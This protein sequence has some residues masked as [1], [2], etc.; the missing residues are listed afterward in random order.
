MS[1]LTP[2]LGVA[3]PSNGAMVNYIDNT[4]TGRTDITRAF[5]VDTDIPVFGDFAGTTL[6][7]IGVY[8]PSTGTWFLDLTNGGTATIALQFGGPQWKPITGDVDGNGTTDLGLYN[9]SDGTWLFCTNLSGQASRSFV[10]GGSAGDVPVMADFNHD[11]TDDPVIY[12]SGQ[13]LVDTNADHVP[14]QTYHFGSFAPGAT[15]LAFDLYGN[16]DPGLAV[17]APQPNGQL[18]WYINPNRDGVTVGQY[19]YGANGSIPFSGNFSTANSLFVNPSTGRDAS[20]AGAYGSPYRTIAAAVAASS[21]GTTIRLMSGA[22]T[23]NVQLVSKSNLKFVGTGMQ[24]SVI[25][26]PRGDGFF[27]LNSD[28]ISFDDMWFAAAGTDGRGLVLLGSSANTGLIRTNLTKWIGVLAGSQNGRSSSINAL[29]SRFDGV[30]T[31]SGVYLDNGA[32]GVFTACTVLDNGYAPDFR[33]DGGGI[34]VGGSS[35]AKIYGTVLMRNRHSG[36]IANTTA[37]VEMYNSY[38]A[39]N[40]LGCGAIFFNAS[41]A[42]LV[43]NTFANNGVTFGAVPGLNGVEFAYDFT[44][45]ASVVG[46]NFIGNTASGIY[47][48]SAPNLVR[49]A[50]NVFAGNWSGVTMFADQPR[51]INVQ[52]VGNYFVTP[53]DFTEATFGIAGIGSRINAQIGGSGGDGNLFDG[54]RDYLFVNPSHSGGAPVQNLGCPNFVVQGNVFRRKGVLIDVSRAVTPC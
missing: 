4:I 30:Q 46:N 29:F 42:I 27:L 32:N 12:N 19:A 16:H 21:P 31:G 34:I 49:I 7:N 35:T 11:G 3:Y 45:Y 40:I 51:A 47:L 22:Y 5:G 38:S 6:S 17:V 20:G 10:Y 54:F 28:N 52:I 48:G 43:G 25:Y 37:R 15:P 18:M 24:S 1:G 50:G 36:V 14:D 23:E 8:R 44:G 26:P 41:T 13:W 39:Q 2:G 33:A 53:P 9:P